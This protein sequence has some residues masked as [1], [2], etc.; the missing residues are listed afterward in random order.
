MDVL[1]EMD[2]KHHLQRRRSIDGRSCKIQASE[3]EEH[4]PDHQ[5]SVVEA[6]PNIESKA[7]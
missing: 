2:I 5:I 3:A 1:Y 6:E 7:L 4:L